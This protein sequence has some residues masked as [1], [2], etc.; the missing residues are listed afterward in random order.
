MEKSDYDYESQGNYQMR[1]NVWHQTSGDK[2]NNLGGFYTHYHTDNAGLA[3][4]G[5]TDSGLTC[6]SQQMPPPQKAESFIDIKKAYSG[7]DV[8][9]FQENMKNQVYQKS[10]FKF[11][12]DEE[13]ERR[14]N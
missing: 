6:K 8:L 13:Y 10:T 11:I 14:Q 12:N 9:R 1:E 5:Q 3:A 4:V 2:N 7:E